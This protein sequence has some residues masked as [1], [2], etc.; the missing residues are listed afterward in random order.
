MA[1]AARG[2]QKRLF[3]QVLEFCEGRSGEVALA[4]VF[5]M[6]ASLL[7]FARPPGEV[8]LVKACVLRAPTSHSLGPQRPL[9]VARPLSP[10]LA[11]RLK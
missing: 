9:A 8:A 3:L 1:L 4:E 11:L 2:V 6:R 10:I 5:V 7:A